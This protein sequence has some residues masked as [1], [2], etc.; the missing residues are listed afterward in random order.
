MATHSDIHNILTYIH[1]HTHM[2]TKAPTC[3]AIRGA[4]SGKA[5]EHFA[6]APKVFDSSEV[7]DIW[8]AVFILLGYPGQRWA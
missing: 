1:T 6:T 3:T 4:E 7:S 5:W 8:G 2:H